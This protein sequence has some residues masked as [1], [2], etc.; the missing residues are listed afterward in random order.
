MSFPRPNSLQEGYVSRYLLPS[1][2]I[3]TISI[4]RIVPTVT[5]TGVVV[6]GS[7]DTENNMLIDLMAAM[8]HKD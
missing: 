5:T 3:T 4:T 6:G 8:S 7:L 2:P 1:F